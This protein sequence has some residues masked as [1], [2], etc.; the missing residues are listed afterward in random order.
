MN[1]DAK[2]TSLQ[3]K[4]VSWNVPY[5]ALGEVEDRA[6]VGRALD[7]VVAIRLAEEA[8]VHV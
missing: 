4:P 2:N 3:E 8:R 5:L 6:R 1:A 7:I